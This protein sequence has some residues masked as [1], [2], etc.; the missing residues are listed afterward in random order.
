MYLN[1]SN[2]HTD[3]MKACEQPLTTSAVCPRNT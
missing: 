2:V 3:S 1:T